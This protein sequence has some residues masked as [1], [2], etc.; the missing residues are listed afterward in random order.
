MRHF[1]FISSIVIVSS[2][3]SICGTFPSLGFGAGA[4]TGGMGM[5]STALFDRSHGGY[6][7]PAGLIAEKGNNFLFSHH[8]WFS[9]V[10]TSFLSFGWGND[11]RGSGFHMLYTKIG[12][13]EEREGPSPEPLSVFSAH[14]WVLGISHAVRIYHLFYLGITVKLLYEK[15]FLE[16]AVGGAADIGFLWQI[17]EN[18][19]VIG[20]VLQHIGKTNKLLEDPISLPL[21]FKL[22]I[23]L[24]FVFLGERWIFLAD[25]VKESGFS[26]HL[27]TGLEFDFRNT[28]F[29]RLGYQTGYETRNITGGVG[30]QWQG[31]RLDYGYMPIS[32]ELGDSHR[33]SAGIAW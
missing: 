22:G 28:L 16:E 33:L 24:P 10:S 14:E 30:I 31:Y 15:I 26:Y 23:A 19:L 8:R 17:R 20:G 18:S 1:I 12:E 3:Q 29:V 6:G 32:G 7:N 21:T 25:G 5:A 27:H 9:D 11:Q 2:A 4:R 13:I